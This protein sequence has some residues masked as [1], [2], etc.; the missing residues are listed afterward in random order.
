MADGRIVAKYLV[1][2]IRYS[3]F[4]SV[5]TLIVELPLHVFLALKVAL[6]PIHQ[7]LIFISSGL[8]MI[9][10]L[11]VLL[12]NLDLPLQSLFLIVQLAETVL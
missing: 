1:P 2:V 4:V 9:C 11:R 10:E 6:M 8:Y 12:G 7:S 3:F 5:S